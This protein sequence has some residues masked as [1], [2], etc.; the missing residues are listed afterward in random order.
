MSSKA[1]LS[2]LTQMNERP[3]DMAR[4]LCE[5][6]QSARVLSGDHPRLMDEYP[7]QWIAVANREVMA[8]GD[9]LEQVLAEVDARNI[10]RDEVIVRFIERTRRTLVL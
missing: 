6:E 2:V 4:S 5:F 10:P 1:I 3:S 8:H 7:D 9:S